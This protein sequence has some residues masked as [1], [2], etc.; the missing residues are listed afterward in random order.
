MALQTLDG[1]RIWLKLL[2]GTAC[3]WC[4]LAFVNPA[5]ALLIARALGASESSAPAW[6]SRGHAFMEA[7]CI[8]TAFGAV[9]VINL[10][11]LCYQDMREFPRLRRWLENHSNADRNAEY[12]RFRYPLVAATAIFVAI[13]TGLVVARRLDANKWAAL[14]IAFVACVIRNFFSAWLLEIMPKSA[15]MVA[16]FAI[17]GLVAILTLRDVKNVVSTEV[18]E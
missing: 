15:Q 13:I 12:G 17:V 8:A 4:I 11:F 1:L 10:W 6:E 2:V 14:S 18:V 16:S 7:T 3:A 9:T 5:Y